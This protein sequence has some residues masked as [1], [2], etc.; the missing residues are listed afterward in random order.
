[1]SRLAPN[2]DRLEDC[3]GHLLFPVF[4]FLMLGSLSWWAVIES[5]RTGALRDGR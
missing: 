5:A 4:I 2:Q 1:M 3:W